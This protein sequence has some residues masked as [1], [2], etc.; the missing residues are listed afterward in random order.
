M[1]GVI[2]G[3]ICTSAASAS[4]GVDFFFATLGNS[5]VK[6]GRELRDG[7]QRM[8]HEGICQVYWLLTVCISAGVRLRLV[9][10]GTVTEAVSVR[11]LMK[12]WRGDVGVWWVGGAAERIEA[13]DLC[14]SKKR[15]RPRATRASASLR[16]QS[17]GQ[18]IA[19]VPSNSRPIFSSLWR[20]GGKGVRALRSMRCPLA[21]IKPTPALGC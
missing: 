13:G 15:F 6:H 1:E 5:V 18:R 14:T 16:R 12:R 17:G 20:S 11:V 2:L 7:M 21:E 4:K 8:S 10:L 19:V 9:I 3:E